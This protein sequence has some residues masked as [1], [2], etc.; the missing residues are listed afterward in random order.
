MGKL[1]KIIFS[2]L[3]FL[4][5]LVI[6]AI[7]VLPMVVDPNDYKDEITAAVKDKT[8]RT[9]EIDGDIQLSV[10]PWLGADIG[11]TRLGNAAGFDEFWNFGNSARNQVYPP[12]G[13]GLTGDPAGIKRF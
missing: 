4:V 1:L 8:G 6:V 11:P 9:L 12:G 3:G 13:D 10:F 5:L 2:L 7:V